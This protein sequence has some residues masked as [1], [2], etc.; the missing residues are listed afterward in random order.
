MV[1]AEFAML[2]EKYLDAR[3]DLFDP[4]VY[5]FDSYLW[6]FINIFSRAIRVRVDA[7]AC[8]ATWI[9]VGSLMWWR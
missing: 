8:E 1:Q 3:P 9:H 6:A 7:Q 4:E 5:N 2:K